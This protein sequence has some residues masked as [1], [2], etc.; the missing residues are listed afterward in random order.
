MSGRWL[1]NLNFS[2]IRQLSCQCSWLRCCPRFAAPKAP[3]TPSSASISGSASSSTPAGSSLQPVASCAFSAPLKHAVFLSGGR[4]C[5]ASACHAVLQWTP[6]LYWTDE[7]DCRGSTG[8][9][10]KPSSLKSIFVAA[11]P[12]CGSRFQGLPAI[13]LNFPSPQPAPSV[14]SHSTWALQQRTSFCFKESPSCWWIAPAPSCSSWFLLWAR[15]CDAA[16]H[17]LHSL[18]AISC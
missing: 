12:S 1:G 17:P 6:S 15:C 4:L 3:K 18:N 7:W 5:S 2:T 9:W 10:L 13:S 8:I 14:H 16:A 11:S